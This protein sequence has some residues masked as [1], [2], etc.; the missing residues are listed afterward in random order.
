MIELIGGTSRAT[1]AQ[2]MRSMHADRKRVFVDLFGW[3][4]PHDGR[5]EADAFD[6]EHAEYLILADDH[7]AHR[8]S[9]R[10][11]P[12]ERPHLMSE[13]FPD[14]CEDGLVTGA[15][16][17][18]I[19]RFCISPRGRASARV[20][21][22]NVLARALVE[23]GLLVGVTRY[24]A[25]CH[26]GLLQQVLSAGWRCKPLGMPRLF[27][28][29]MVG[30]FVIEIDARTLQLMSQAWRCDAPALRLAQPPGALAA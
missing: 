28:G 13:V 4:V 19:T 8:A 10:L 11:L 14:F 3:D 21:A 5:F 6:D 2:L 22:R 23:Y 24:T 26:M 17:R 15:H 12:T 30:A 1:H 18:E 20:E 16:V 7:G 29:E 9:I 27:C 25:V